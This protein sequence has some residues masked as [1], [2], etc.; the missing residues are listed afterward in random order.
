P[1]P[2]QRGVL[3]TTPLGELFDV[4][5]LL[6]HQPIPAGRRVGILT[7]AGGPGILAADAC[8]AQGLELPPLSP[9]TA[10]ALRAFLPGGPSG[11]SLTPPPCPR[12]RGKPPRG[13]WRGRTGRASPCSRR[14]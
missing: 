6:S 3:R 4:A 2:R 11:A 13:W 5:M 9:K 14:S 10:A 1:P 7:N 8:E 12:G